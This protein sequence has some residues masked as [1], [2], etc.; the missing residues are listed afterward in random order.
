MLQ[1]SRQQK[2]LGELGVLVIIMNF[3]IGDIIE[4]DGLLGVVTELPGK[5]VPD[6]HLGIWFGEEKPKRKSEGG[7]VKK[8]LEIF[9]IPK[10]YCELAQKPTYK[11]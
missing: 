2:L 6:D 4:M 1:K 11:H 7:E 10:E 8:S 5:N 3:K 9:T